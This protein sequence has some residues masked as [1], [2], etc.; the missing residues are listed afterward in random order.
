MVILVKRKKIVL[1]NTY[2]RFKAFTVHQ[3]KAALKVSTDSCIFG[4]WCAHLLGNGDIV[5]RNVLDIGAGSGLLMLMIA[6]QSEAMIEGIEIDQ[7]SFEQGTENLAASAW[8]AR[9]R[10]YF[11][12][13]RK[14]PFPGKY[15]FIVSNPPFFE[16][17]LKPKYYAK[18]IS[19]HADTL[20]LS[21]LFTTV[22]QCLNPSG[23]FACLLPYNRKEEAIALAQRHQLQLWAATDIQ[24]GSQQR[25]TRTMLCF[26][27][28]AASTHHHTLCISEN[29]NYTA[30]FTALLKPYYLYL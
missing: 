19:R 16:G 25:F 28:H 22:N 23:Y 12:D 5:A 2:F 6:Q 17:D 4:A 26:T 7:N 29:G 14:F 27:A 24:P 9:L 8:S 18:R 20:T 13:V 30:A 15:D 10:L 1:P 21:E 3:Q 11:G